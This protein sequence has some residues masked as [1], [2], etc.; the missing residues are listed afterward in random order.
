MKEIR[1]ISNNNA[2]YEYLSELL[3]QVK[4]N[5]DI[6]DNNFFSRATLQYRSL[7]SRLTSLSDVLY[8]FGL[9]YA[10]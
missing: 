1:I 9:L 2:H 7:S 3:Y 10:K 6:K 4:L 8:I 5:K